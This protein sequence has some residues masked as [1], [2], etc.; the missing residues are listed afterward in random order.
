MLLLSMYVTDIPIP[1][2]AVNA[3]S[4]PLVICMPWYDMIGV[5]CDGVCVR[6]KV[7]GLM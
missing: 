2:D 1:A 6:P 5:H 7:S 3:A 4:N